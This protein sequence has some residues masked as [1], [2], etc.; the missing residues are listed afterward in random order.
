ME[1]RREPFPCRLLR[2]DGCAFP[3][4]VAD[5]DETSNRLLDD[6]I[7]LRLIR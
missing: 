3:E 7:M 5:A 2:R 6:A 4:V 1:S